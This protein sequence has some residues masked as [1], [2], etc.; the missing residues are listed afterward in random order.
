M[1]ITDTSTLI[2]KYKDKCLEE[3]LRF[4]RS[5]NAWDFLFFTKKEGKE[6]RKEGLV[7]FNRYWL[8]AEFVMLVIL[9][10]ALL[11]L[12]IMMVMALPTMTRRRNFK[13]VLSTYLYS[14]CFA[15]KTFHYVWCAILYEFRTNCC[16]WTPMVCF[17]DLNIS[18]GQTPSSSL[19]SS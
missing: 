3:F 7:Y 13:N 4:R 12:M 9:V 17:R 1:V 2:T 5:E 14:C 16:K 10:V 15:L 11:L 18:E 19:L 6:G 8:R